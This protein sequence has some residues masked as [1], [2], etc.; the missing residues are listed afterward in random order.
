MRIAYIGHAYHQKTRSTRFLIDLLQ[1]HASVDL[2]FGEPGDHTK[3]PWAA[4]FDE[5]NYDVIVIFQLHE[6]FGLLSGLHP[7]VVFVPM[8]DAIFWAGEFYW[9]S[10]FNAA[11]IL[12]FSW[13]LRTNVMRQGAV[14]A[15]FQYYPDPTKYPLVEDFSTLRGI[16]WY[17]TRAI[18]PDQAFRLCRRTR[19]ER[20]VVHNAPDPGHEAAGDWTRPPNIGRLDITTWSVDRNAYTAG[21]RDAN[22]FFAP[23]LLE[24][25]GMSVLEAL[26]SGLCVVAPDAPT[27]NEYISNGTNGLLYV[28]ERRTLLD[29]ADARR[30]G[31]RARESVERGYQRW[32]TSIPALLDFIVTPTATVRA[33][34]RTVIPVQTRFE[35]G[36]RRA[37][38]ERPLVS[39]VTVCRNAEAELEATMASVLG[40]TGCDFEYVVVDGLST[41]GTLAIIQRHADRIAAWRSAQDN[42]PFDAMNAALELTRG[43]WVLFMNAGDSFVGDEALRRMFARLPEDADV[44]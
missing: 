21:L 24:G 18:T 14:Y 22:V 36:P 34:A 17:R 39:V 40:Q 42:G 11:K 7:N 29:F 43:E 20:F 27:M 28:P 26:A 9:K 41:D 3:W 35:T 5:N 8:Y 19:F 4:E 1:Q 12:C 32:L 2:L 44:V 15:G 10:A 13:A 31:A 16:L 25:I 23:R 38:A 6:A 33:G 37:P 30:I